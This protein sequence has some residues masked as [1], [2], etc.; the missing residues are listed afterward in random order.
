MWDFDQMV[1]GSSVDTDLQGTRIL[2][3]KINSSRARDFSR[4]RHAGFL[5][6][7]LPFFVEIGRPMIAGETSTSMGVSP[8]GAKDL[9]LSVYHKFFLLLKLLLW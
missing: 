6:A 1:A 9:Q 4:G 2:S 5:I 8:D 7:N 3:E